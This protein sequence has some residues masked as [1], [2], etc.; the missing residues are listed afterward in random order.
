MRIEEVRSL[1]DEARN[2]ITRLAQGSEMVNRVKEVHAARSGQSSISDLKYS[3][4][5]TDEEIAFNEEVDEIL[6]TFVAMA[7][8]SATVSGQLFT[9]SDRE[10]MMKY[11]TDV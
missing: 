4:P 8:I 10:T 3:N 11:R 2:A 7:S 6:S 9:G 1:R 5:S